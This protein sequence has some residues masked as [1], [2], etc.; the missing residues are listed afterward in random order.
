MKKHFFIL[1]T[2]LACLNFTAC[3]GNS[4]NETAETSVSVSQNDPLTPL[5]ELIA[6][7]EANGDEYTQA[8]WEDINKLYQITLAEIPSQKLNI[9]K[10]TELQKLNIQYLQL[11]KEKRYHR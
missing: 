1:V 6:E 8:Q 11:M 9:E 10:V 7:V 4:S 2:C 3:S 5:K